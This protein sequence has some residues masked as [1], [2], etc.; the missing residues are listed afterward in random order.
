[1]TVINVNGTL[2]AYIH[3]PYVLQEMLEM[4]PGKIDR[5]RA[6]DATLYH[7][8]GR[9]GFPDIWTSD[10]FYDWRYN[11]NKAMEMSQISKYIPLMIKETKEIFDV[12][13]KDLKENNFDVRGRELSYNIISKIILGK[14]FPSDFL[15]PYKSSPN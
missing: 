1:M 3:N 11:F 9:R 4:M 8:G 5:W 2:D 10:E 7:L 12:W 15:I 13:R 14:D 6:V